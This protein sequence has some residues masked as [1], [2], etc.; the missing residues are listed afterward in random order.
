MIFTR[1]K[2][3]VALFLLFAITSVNVHAYQWEAILTYEQSEAEDNSLEADST[4]INATWYFTPVKSNGG[5]LAESAY[6]TQASSL[7]LG[8]TDITIDFTG[9]T[10]FDGSAITL[11]ALYVVP[12]SKYFFGFDYIDAPLKD[13][14]LK[15]D[16]SFFT[17]TAGKYFSDTLSGFL[18]YS[19][20]STDTPFVNI[21]TTS[22][23]VG[24]KNIIKMNGKNINMEATVLTET[25]EYSDSTA[26]ETNTS[27]LL[28]GDYYF[29]REFGLGAQLELNNGDD[30]STEGT[31]FEIN[32]QYFFKPELAI[33]ASYETFS[34][35]NAG[36][37]DEDTLLVSLLARF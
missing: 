1:Q 24:V 15:L 22:I 37:A 4:E 34:A 13:G 14:A 28:S 9:S 5:P 35:D 2:I 12:E 3:S 7:N 25:Q 6:L 19:D 18:A 36:E 33:L 20:D 21:D 10:K 32:A 31:T 27:I 23:A 30:T 17:L 11:G 16:L 8:Y 26:D 29:S